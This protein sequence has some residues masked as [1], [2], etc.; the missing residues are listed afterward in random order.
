MTDS[1]CIMP[2]I[3]HHI[4]TEGTTKL[5]C[6]SHPVEGLEKFGDKKHVELRKKFL[7]G[8][9]IAACDRCWNKE[10]KNQISMRQIENTRWSKKMPHVKDVDNQK[11]YTVH[12]AF[13]N[14]CN[15]ACTMCGPWS[16]TTWGKLLKENTMVKKNG[17]ENLDDINYEYITH[18]YLAGG[19]PLII[20]QFKK[21]VEKLD[22]NKVELVINTNLTKLSND[23]VNLISK[24][25]KKNMTVSV[26]AFGILNEYIRW[27][28]N[29]K[30]FNNNLE[31][32]RN[33]NIPI[34]FNTCLMNINF[35]DCDKLFDWMLNFEPNLVSVS[36]IVRPDYLNFDYLKQ[37]HAD[38]FVNH[39]RKMANHPLSKKLVNLQKFFLEEIKNVTTYNPIDYSV[40]LEKLNIQDRLKGNSLEN[41]PCEFVKL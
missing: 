15:L 11:I 13:S 3:H 29:W 12:Y 9:K 38:K 19:E 7:N 16:S 33:H 14:H 8:E 35:F 10:K 40:I 28:M 30:T 5:C 1:Y 26:E 25:K 36:E 24:F 17:I 22:Y 21:F 39:C 18:V 31:K 2:F 4:N 37:H 34:M 27:P 32:L 6:Q 41:I 20:P 23:W